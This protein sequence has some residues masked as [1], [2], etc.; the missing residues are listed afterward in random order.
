MIISSIVVLIVPKL[1]GVEEYGYW[2]LYLFYT[3][4]V[5]FL[6]FGWNDGIYLRY[7]G[8]EYKELDKN[9]FFSQFWMMVFLQFVIGLVILVA[10]T[11]YTTD[12]NKL[13]IFKMTALCTLLVNVRYMLIYVLQGTNKIK[14]FAKITMIEKVLYCCLILLLLLLGIRQYKLLIVADIVGKVVSLIYSTYC[15]RD[16]VFKKISDF[17]FNI[18]ETINNISAGIKLMI[19]NIASILI[20]GIVRFGIERSWDVSTFGKIS[21]IISISNLLMIFINAVGIVIFPMLRRTNED[22]LPRI[23]TT[24]RTLLMV[25]LLGLLV[26]YYPLKVII[27]W[28][29]PQYSVSLAFM[30]I[31]FPMCVY[32][33]KMALLINT[34]FKT[35]R[36]E[37]LMLSVNLVSLFLS[38]ILTIMF[39]IIFKN[40]TLAIFSIVLLLAF[41]CVL[42]E[43]FLSKI[44]NISVYKDI[45]LEVIMSL[46]FISTGWFITSSKGVVLYLVAF[47]LYLFFKRRDITITFQKVKQLVRI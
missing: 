36:K 28:W 19:A 7:G 10:S 21:L 20:I 14:E 32:E 29:L 44:L 12:I 5:G 17:Y 3:A 31:V 25:L 30:A 47:G 41:R 1:I 38:I 40:L 26:S 39:T 23:Y 2:Q 9:L 45:L 34:Y 4:Y 37:K 35:L 33:G 24:M 46:I 22:N 13:F 27:S 11:V 42:A 8:K 18:V 16:I 43:W 15:C 6:H